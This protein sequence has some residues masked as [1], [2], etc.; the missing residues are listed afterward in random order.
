MGHFT[1]VNSFGPSNPPHQVNLTRE[2]PKDPQRGQAA[3]SP[4]GSVP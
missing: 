3:N 2:A 1:C 4:G